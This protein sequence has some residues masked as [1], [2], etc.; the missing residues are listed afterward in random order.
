MDLPTLNMIFR[1]GGSFELECRAGDQV[2]RNVLIVTFLSIDFDLLPLA[3][4]LPLPTLGV[5]GLGL[6]IFSAS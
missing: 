1:L 2:C 3:H 4:Q 5:M 6:D